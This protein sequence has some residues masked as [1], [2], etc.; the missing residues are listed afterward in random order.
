MKERVNGRK[1]FRLARLDAAIAR[2]L[3]DADAGCTVLAE[4][5]F[6]RLEVKYSRPAAGQEG[7]P[8][9]KSG[10]TKEAG[11]SR[12]FPGPSFDTG[13]RRAQPLLR[14]SGGEC[15]ILRGREGRSPP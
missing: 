4:E 9:I 14:M 5:A 10:V 7:G 13:L 1:D 12:K 3:T 15:E 8:R 11:I 6:D 2:G